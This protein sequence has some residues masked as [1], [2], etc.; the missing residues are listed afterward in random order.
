DLAAWLAGLETV[1]DLEPLCLA[2]LPRAV[3][4]INKSNQFNMA[5]RRLDESDLRAWAGE[6]GH[7]VWTGRVHDKFGDQGICLVISATSGD[8]EARRVDF[9]MSCRVMGR[10]IELAALSHVARQLR[11]AG[12]GRLCASLVEGPA[13]LPIQR[14][15]TPLFSDAQSQL[16]DPARLTPPSHVRLQE[17]V[18]QP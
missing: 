7:H 5:G 9:V 18:A 14:F 16:V 1:L 4:L 11:A 8:G 12:A 10:D 6:P 13:N 17:P 3:Q 2:N 15:L